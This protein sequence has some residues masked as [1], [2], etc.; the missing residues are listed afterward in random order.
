MKQIRLALITLVSSST[1]AWAQDGTLPPSYQVNVD[2]TGQNIV[3]DAANE[4]S[5]C[6][7]PTNPKRLAIG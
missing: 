3:G 6:L 2:A 7:D 5:L 1:T 4:P